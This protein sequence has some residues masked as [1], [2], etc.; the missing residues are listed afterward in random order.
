MTL[1]IRGPTLINVVFEKKQHA[2]DLCSFA[3]YTNM[4]DELTTSTDGTV[5]AT[6]HAQRHGVVGTLRDV[7]H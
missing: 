1:S 3:V 6:D 2:C 5:V 4:H 7:L